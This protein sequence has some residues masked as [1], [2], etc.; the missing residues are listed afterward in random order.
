[1]KPVDDITIMVL[2]FKDK[3]KAWKTDLLLN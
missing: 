1:M 3:K 2:Q